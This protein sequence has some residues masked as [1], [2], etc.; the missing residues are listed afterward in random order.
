MTLADGSIV[1]LTGPVREWLA[2][3]ATL[4]L[5]SG[6]SIDFERL[7]S[8]EILRFRSGDSE[9]EA[10]LTLAD[11]RTMRAEIRAIELR[12]SNDLGDFTSPFDRVKRV[13]F[14]R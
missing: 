13:D 2:G 8:F 3:G 4:L 9:G 5:K 6:Q 14:V 7:S 10:Q 12:G 11:G 1:T